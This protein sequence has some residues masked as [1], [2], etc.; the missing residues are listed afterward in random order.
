MTLDQMCMAESH[1]HE[2]EAPKDSRITTGHMDQGV[3][4]SMGC[5]HRRSQDVNPL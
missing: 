3:K 4:E 5:Y 2:C 1:T